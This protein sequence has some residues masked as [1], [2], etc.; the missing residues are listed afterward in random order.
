MA[1][2]VT[3]LQRLTAALFKDHKGDKKKRREKLKGL[4]TGSPSSVQAGFNLTA[5]EQ[6]ALTLTSTSFSVSGGALQYN[7]IKET[8]V[9]LAADIRHFPICR[10]SRKHRFSSGSAGDAPAW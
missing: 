3:S 1:A 4:L 2:G 9:Q 7:G 6:T 5:E 10:S 8:S